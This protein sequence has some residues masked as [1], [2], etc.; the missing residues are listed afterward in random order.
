MYFKGQF[1]KNWWWIG[2]VV[3]L[4]KSSTDHQSHQDF[5]FCKPFMYSPNLAPANSC[6]DTLLGTKLV[7][8]PQINAGMVE[9]SDTAIEFV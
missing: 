9:K 6:P 2:P 1:L 3:A 5:S 8:Q 4:D 7:N